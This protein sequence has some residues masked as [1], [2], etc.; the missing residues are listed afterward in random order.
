M[1]SSRPSSNPS[2]SS[3]CGAS[4][5]ATTA[6]RDGV[7]PG[8]GDLSGSDLEFWKNKH[9]NRSA[10]EKTLSAD[11]EYWKDKHDDRSAPEVKHASDA[12]YWMDKHDERSSP[13]EDT[14]SQQ[15]SDEDPLNK[16]DG[17][18]AVEATGGR[19]AGQTRGAK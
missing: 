9:D 7:Q 8:R 4:A 16:H 13:E 12:A 6:Q 10:P 18:S 11:S 17:P 5:P 19:G 14:S 15:G 1:F 3:P 2:S